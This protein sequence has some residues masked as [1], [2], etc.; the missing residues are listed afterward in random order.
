MHTEMTKLTEKIR[1]AGLRPTRQRLAL[2]ELLYQNGDRHVTAEMLHGETLESDYK[3]S[4][5]TIY[6][7]LHQFTAARLL[8]E[9]VVDSGKSYFDT[10]MSEHHHFFYED[11]KDLVDIPTD[12]TVIGDLPDAPD[13]TSISRIDVVI[14][15]TSD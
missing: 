5:A 12:N 3:M 4:L 15:V 6:N 14:R 2:A 9:V 11:S 1:E 13:G 7:N 10:N 8:K